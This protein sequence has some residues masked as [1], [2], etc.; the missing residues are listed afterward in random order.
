[1]LKGCIGNINFQN[2]NKNLNKIK[3]LEGIFIL[4]KLLFSF[5]NVIHHQN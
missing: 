3:A 1:M 4:K 5:D 2:K